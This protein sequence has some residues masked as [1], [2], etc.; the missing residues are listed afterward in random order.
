MKDDSNNNANPIYQGNRTF[1]TSLIDS[2]CSLV[3]HVGRSFEMRN[4]FNDF[5]SF[6][7]LFNI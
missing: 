7:Y 5:F 1:R 4:I 3:I 2:A 6:F